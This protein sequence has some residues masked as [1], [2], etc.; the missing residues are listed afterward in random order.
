[1]NNQTNNHPTITSLKDEAVRSIASM[2]VVDC[3]EH[4]FWPDH[5]AQDVEEWAES[6][7]DINQIGA[8]ANQHWHEELMEILTIER[9][10]RFYQIVNQIQQG[11][12]EKAATVLRVLKHDSETYNPE[13]FKG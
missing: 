7:F 9:S 1:M 5:D 2:L 6:T 12:F 8:L 11:A 13:C 3:V 4:N 10:E